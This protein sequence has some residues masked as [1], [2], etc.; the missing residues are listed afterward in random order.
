FEADIALVT[1]LR[2][3]MNLVA[4]EYVA[5]KQKKPGVLILS[6]MA[7]A[8]D[9]LPE[10]LSVNP[11]DTVAMTSMIKRALSMPK[12]EQRERMTAMQR[13]I[14]TYT[15]Q[16]WSKDF[17]D[18]LLFMKEEQTKNSVKFITPLVERKILTHFNKAKKKLLLLDY[19]GTLKAFTS[20]HRLQDS[21]PPK[22]LLQLLS[23]LIA[24]DS[25]KVAIVSGRDKKSLESWFSHLPVSLIAEHGAWIKENG[26][27]QHVAESFEEE[28]ASLR[29]LLHQFAE[30][31]PGAVVE[32]KE[33]SLV[34]HYRDVPTELA[35]VRTANLRHELQTLIKDTDI[36]MYSGH[37]IIEI[38][39]TNITKG[40]ATQTLLESFTADFV[41]CIGDDY[42]D[43]DMFKT[44]PESAYTIKVGGNET[45][46]QYQ[47]PTVKSV[48]DFLSR[49]SR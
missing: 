20:S 14:S 27:W 6:E 33:F 16:R 32:E 34:W 8:I 15:V 9:E 7:G 43:E 44:L 5:S 23:S 12:R 49:L 25:V 26:L 41:L 1:P 45:A 31:T 4:K 39:R 24:D 37:K 10:S 13:R 17:L 48:L 18:E 36:G 35:Y 38:K 40:S 42:T 28:K 30:R 29:P 19:D 22:Q 2:D 3:G 47:L 46:A 21:R 11:S